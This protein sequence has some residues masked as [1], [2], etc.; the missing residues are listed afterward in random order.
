M[1]ARTEMLTRAASEVTKRQLTTGE[2]ARCSFRYVF[3]D[4]PINASKIISIEVCC[5]LRA[6]LEMLGLSGRKRC[7]PLA[8]CFS[9]GW[10]G[11][12][13]MTAMVRH[14]GVCLS[15]LAQ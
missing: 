13:T 4:E 9:S 11:W 3:G 8:H 12:A 14:S 7:R 15:V 5:Q 2:H 6:E 10:C 1:M